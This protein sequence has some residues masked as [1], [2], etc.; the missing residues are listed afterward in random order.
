MS[1]S[2]ARLDLQ[3]DEREGSKDNVSRFEILELVEAGEVFRCNP[4]YIF[5]QGKV[6]APHT[7]SDALSALITARLDMRGATCLEPPRF[8]ALN[9]E[10]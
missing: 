2:A 8:Q 7:T 1:S 10:Y 9:K 6:V 3:E 5:Q 4:L